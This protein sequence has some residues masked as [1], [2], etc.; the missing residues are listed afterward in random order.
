MSSVSSCLSTEVVTHWQCASE[1]FSQWSALW[2]RCP[3]ATTFQ[4]PDWVWS[5]METFR[6]SHPVIVVVRND[7][8]V[9]GL[10]PLLI[11][12]D[13]DQRVLGLM[14]GGVS[15]Y[16]D[17]L[18]DSRFE[19]EAIRAIW[20][21]VAET[22]GWDRLWFSDLPLKSVFLRQSEARFHFEK[23]KHD[24]CPVLELPDEARG[25]RAVV[26]SRQLRNW[27]NARGRLE[28]AGGGHLEIANSH[29][30]DAL[31]DGMFQLHSARWAV[32]G[33]SGVLSSGAV[34]EFHRRATR[35]LLA[36]G[37]LRLYALRHKRQLVA[38]LY[39]FF[40]RDTVYC[41]LQGFDPSLTHLSLGTQI[42]G[43]VIEDALRHGKKQVD[44]LRGREAYKRTW[45][46][47]D[48]ATFSVSAKRAANPG[49][50][51]A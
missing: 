24:V 13:G 18:I 4:R 15:D 33:E 23:Q 50:V 31:L 41:Y 27:R 42:L 25:L 28:R 20:Q 2:Q 21:Q 49:R 45:G 51:A 17:V 6:P 1:L 8:E 46:A 7:R 30:L 43:I 48:V 12:S 40:E 37:V 3:S 47:S 39:S 44:F 32:V 14:A 11:Y 10:A 34:Q 9:V 22:P 19:T 26:P 38:F 5:W 36:A 29:T 35:R 16:L